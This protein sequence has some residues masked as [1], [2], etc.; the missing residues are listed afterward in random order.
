VAGP[1][2]IPGWKGIAAN[3]D[4]GRLVA[5]TQ[6]DD[7]IFRMGRIYTSDDGGLNWVRSNASYNKGRWWDVTMDYDG[8][9][10]A[11]VTYFDWTGTTFLAGSIYISPDF[12]R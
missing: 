7:A 6:V 1:A 8:I 3:H 12:G 9:R 4:G 5:S 2:Y 10:L 11:A